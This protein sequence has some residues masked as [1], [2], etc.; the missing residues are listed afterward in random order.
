MRL[1]RL[2]KRLDLSRVQPQIEC[3]ERVVEVKQQAG[4]V[5]ASLQLIG[6]DEAEVER[7]EMF[8]FDAVL[9]QM[10]G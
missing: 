7:L 5:R 9:E 8:V 1:V 10:Q 4:T 3:L 2:F 6:L